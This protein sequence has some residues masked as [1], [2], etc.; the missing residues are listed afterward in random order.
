[1]LVYK[2][3][4]GLT[5]PYLTDNCQLVGN[6]GRRRLR[7]TDVDTCH[8][9]YLGRKPGSATGASLSPV[10]GFGTLPA[11]L[12]QPDIE[13][14]TFRRLLKPA[15]KMLYR[16]GLGSDSDVHY[17][18]NDFPLFDFDSPFSTL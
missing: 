8:V 7:S 9:S 12:R 10:H 15:Y 13:L 2:S 3:L 18:A 11:E 4:H 5:T 14:V 17:S 16:A 1:V 6:S